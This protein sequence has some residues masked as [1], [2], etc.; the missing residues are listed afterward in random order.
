MSRLGSAIGI[1]LSNT[2]FEYK[3]TTNYESITNL[4]SQAISK[5][6]SI[7]DKINHLIPQYLDNSPENLRML[8]Q[9]LYKLATNEASAI[10]FNQIML[11]LGIL[12]V[13]SAPLI[14][15][16]RGLKKK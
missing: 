13:L 3:I 14:Y 16:V 1:A 15:L 7:L 10:A 11:L 12:A 9:I 6:E 2:L 8:M 5:S 4:S